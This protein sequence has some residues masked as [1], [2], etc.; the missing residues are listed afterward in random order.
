[1]CVWGGGRVCRTF[2][3]WHGYPYPRFICSFAC[4]QQRQ[5]QQALVY[6]LVFHL[7]ANPPP[8]HTLYCPVHRVKPTQSRN[9]AAMLNTCMYIITRAGLAGPGQACQAAGWGCRLHVGRKT[10]LF[11]VRLSTSR[12]GYVAYPT[13]HSPLPFTVYHSACLGPMA[14]KTGSRPGRFKGACMRACDC[15]SNGIQC[16]INT[17]VL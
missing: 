12:R 14:M 10:F 17:H 6:L 16:A 2:I 3:F 1:M 7:D 5:R 11:C 9:P 15:N 13:T 4:L 8:P